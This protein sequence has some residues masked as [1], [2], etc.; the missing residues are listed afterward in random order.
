MSREGNS[1]GV[2][3]VYVIRVAAMQDI[4]ICTGIRTRFRKNS[5]GVFVC[6]RL[7]VLRFGVGKFVHGCLFLLVFCGT[8]DKSVFGRPAAR[9]A[10]ATCGTIVDAWHG[11]QSEK[12]GIRY[13]QHMVGTKALHYRRVF[14]PELPEFHFFAFA[15][16]YHFPNFPVFF[17]KYVKATEAFL[18]FFPLL[19]IHKL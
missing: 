2:M 12:R 10:A 11:Y 17:S 13:R 19:E 6:G 16:F 3:Q 4:Y 18:I 8:N 15:Q 5:G 9:R 7:V 14:F 1:I